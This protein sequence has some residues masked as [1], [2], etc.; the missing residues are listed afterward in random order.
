MSFE[1]PE[2]ILDIGNATLRVGKLEVA[3]T[4]GLNQGLQNI[5]KNDLLITENTEYSI[6]HHWGIKLPTTWV[7]DFDVKGHSGKYVEFNFYNE[8]FTSNTSG[9]TLNFNDTTLSLRYD[10]GSW[11]TA[12]IPTIVNT[13]RKVNI[14]FERNVIAVSIDG[15]RVL[16]Y[17][18]AGNPPPVMSRV[19]STT[20]SA[21]VNVFIEQ[22]ASNSKFKNLR[23][24]NGRFISDKTSNIAFIGGNLGVG[25]NSPKESLDIRG[26]MHLTRVSNVSQIKVDSNVVTEYTGPHDRP[27]RKYPEVAMTAN[28]DKGYVASTNNKTPG[29]GGVPYRDAFMAYDGSFTSMNAM[30]QTLVNSY[31]SNG[32]D[33]NGDTFT[34]GGISYVGHWN[35]LQLPNPVKVDKIEIIAL[36][37]TANPTN[38]QRPDQG[39]FL[40]SIDGTNWE[41]IYSFSSGTL[42]WS[43]AG[44]SSAIRKITTITNITNTNK[45]NYLVLVVEKIPSTSG[46]TLVGVVELRYYGHEEG[47]GSLDT[48]LKTVYNVPATTGTQLE[49][50]YDAKDLTTMPSTVTD[51]SPNTNTGALS[52]SPP[53]LDTTDGIESFK[54]DASSSQRITSTIDTSYWGTNKLHSVSF[55][56][57]ADVINGKYNIFHIGNYAA[58]QASA[59]WISDGS[60]DSNGGNS[61]NWWFYGGDA[62]LKTSSFSLALDTWYHIALSFDGST[63]KLYVN[64]KHI[65]FSEGIP[66]PTANLPTGIPDSASLVVGATSQPGDYF[67]GSIAN[68]RIYG[69]KVLNAEQ[70]QE[71]YDY[72]KDYFLG[73]KSQVTLYKGHLGVGVTEPSGQ[74]ELAGDER[75]QEYPP[76]A[77]TGWETYMEGHG[78]FRAG[79]SGHDDYFGAWDRWKVFNKGFTTS[80][81]TAG[82]SY[83]GELSYSTSTGLYTGHVTSSQI[84]RLGGILGDYF[85]LDMPYKISLKHINLTSANQNRS[86]TEFIILGSNDGSTWTQIKSFS[87]SFTGSGQTLPFQ[88]NSNEYFSYFGLV[89]TKVVASD[90]YL[91]L[92]EWQ[93]FGTPGPTTLDKGSLTLGRSLDVPRISRYDVDTETPRPEKLILDYDTTINNSP[94]DI[95]GSGNHGTFFGH[96]QYSAADKAFKFDGTG[97]TVYVDHNGNMGATTNFPT[98]DAIYTMSCWIKA[99]SAQYSS[100]AAVF[101]F[102]SAWTSYQLAGIYHGINGRINMDIGGHNM[103]TATGTIQS[104]RWY[105]VAIVK[106]GTGTITSARS[107]GSIYIDGVEIDPANLTYNAGGTQALQSIDNISI[108]SNFN[109]SPGSF[110]EAFNGLVSKPQIWNVALENS[111][112]RKIYN[113]GRTG[114]SMVIS[115]TAV[116]I[117]KVPE[118]HLDVRGSLNVTGNFNGNSPLKF[119]RFRLNLPLNNTG[120]SYIRRN[121]GAAGFPSDYDDTKI[122]SISSVVYN[123]NGDVVMGQGEDTAWKHSIY[124]I[125]LHSGSSNAGLVIYQKGSNTQSSSG[126][127]RRLE[128]LV[129]TY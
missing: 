81:G 3:E 72:Q 47:S 5:V 51:L 66:T 96:A 116:G 121:D 43:E 119:Y 31:D 100:D 108:G 88:V 48:T 61:L 58:N 14:F 42:G 49:V 23:I 123:H 65:E 40:G 125:P 129:V 97:D 59:F 15:T 76:R 127:D 26:N 13:Y 124:S 50:Y 79:K 37:S 34:A 109:G 44:D 45:Y 36:Q 104:N 35:K 19:I 105:H 69:A 8:G 6:N 101:Y 24:V 64:G 27:L 106:R 122:I 70:I 28:S 9:Y 120:T 33:V 25:V 7:A 85:I 75:I 113:L 60:A 99:N 118:A 114:R 12:T 107:Y 4:S 92:S 39:A 62:T 83:H 84:E 10:N 71:L 91:M 32:D 54:F 55:W 17:K 90:G 56:F 38:D 126:G 63:K 53:T 29:T 16:Y 89:V 103:R 20:G 73:S 46:E 2:G 52:T 94:L 74:L 30:W 21:F 77:M 102:G 128:I 80:G 86:P 22:N 93:L 111:E 117:G 82:D 41:L 78:V 110:G 112:I 87:S 98:G 95:S 57:K 68:F 18:H 11:T 67:D 115:D 1:P